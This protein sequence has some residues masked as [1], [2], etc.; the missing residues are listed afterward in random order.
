M[1]SGC[2]FVSWSLGLVKLIVRVLL[3]LL[4]VF[5]GGKLVIGHNGLLR[6]LEIQQQNKALRYGNDSLS[7]SLA[8]M[9]TQKNRLLKDSSYMEEIARTRFGMS[10]PGENVFRFMEPQDS[11]A[12]NTN[13]QPPTSV[14]SEFQGVTVTKPD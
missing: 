14:G 13:T 12:R 6:Q 7:N 3:G 8:Q 11:I 4:F 5:M 2:I 10:K 1:G 9:L